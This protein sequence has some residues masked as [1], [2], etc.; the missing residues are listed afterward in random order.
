M[1]TK[2]LL[3]G[4]LLGGLISTALSNIP[5]IS[6][7][8]CLLCVGFWGGAVFAVWYYK[9]QTGSVTLGQ[10]I[11]IGAVAGLFA[12]VF[13]FIL[14]LIGAAG[15]G[16]MMENMKSVL[17][18]DAQIKLPQPGVATVLFNILGAGVNIVFG[19]IGGLVGGLIFKPKAVPPTA[20]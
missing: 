14:S 2:N 16:P 13:G 9:R 11:A 5:I 6:L 20:M 18:Q 4:G 17:P 1:N 15:V 3:I 7:V 12:G 19:A 8:N 10:G